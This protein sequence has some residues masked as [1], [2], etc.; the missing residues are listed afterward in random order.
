MPLVLTCDAP[1]AFASLGFAEGRWLEHP[2][3]ETLLADSNAGNL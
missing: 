3:P 1:F 2:L